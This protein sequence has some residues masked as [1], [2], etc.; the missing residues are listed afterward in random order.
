MQAEREVGSTAGTWKQK[1]NKDADYKGGRQ[2]R[3]GGGHPE[4]GHR[5]NHCR[6]RAGEWL[7]RGVSRPGAGSP[8]SPEGQAQ[9]SRVLSLSSHP[10]CSSFPAG[11]TSACDTV[12]SQK[13][14]RDSVPRIALGAGPVATPC[15]ACPQI[16]DPGEKQVPSINH[17]VCMVVYTGGWGGERK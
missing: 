14:V 7:S 15:L 11:H 13:L 6:E 17:A 16:P 12:S 3:V 1:F 2:L 8:P 5:G 9:A 10:G 4:F